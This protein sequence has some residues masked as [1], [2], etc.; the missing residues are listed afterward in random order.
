MRS[1]DSALALA[2]GVLHAPRRAIER[3]REPGAPALS[4]R[5]YASYV[6]AC[7]AFHWLK[8]EGFPP[9]P[10][11]VP[12]AESPLWA[13]LAAEPILSAML[14]L[15]CGYYGRMLGKGRLSTRLALATLATILPA[16]LIVMTSPRFGSAGLLAVAAGMAPVLLKVGRPLWIQTASWI[17]AV[18]ATGLALSPFFIACALAG[19]AP[20]YY[21]CLYAML[22]WTI[23]LVAW[24]LGRLAHMST[25]RAFCAVLLSLIAQL[26]T[27]GALYRTGLLPRVLFNAIMNP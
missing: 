17:M 27:V 19:Y 15:F 4:A 26:V 6:A 10:P 24:G 12:A 21:F 11:G 3:M 16:S 25:P 18:S 20:A 14:V 22:F 8:P 1:K 5:V 9:P 7:A 2:C 13:T 23:G